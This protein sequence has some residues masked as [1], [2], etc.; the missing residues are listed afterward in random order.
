MQ[1]AQ[2]SMIRRSVAVPNAPELSLN[3]R[4]RSIAEALSQAP[5]ASESHYSH[6]FNSKSSAA[7]SSRF[8]EQP[9]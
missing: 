8:R 4:Q 7:S 2:T 3:A 1:N 5:T 6:Y 9:P